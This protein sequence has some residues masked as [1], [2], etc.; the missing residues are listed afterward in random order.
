MTS[1]RED[2]SKPLSNKNVSKS[3]NDRLPEDRGYGGQ[4]S[5]GK[6]GKRLAGGG[7]RA[8]S[9]RQDTSVVILLLKGFY[10]N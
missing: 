6:T 8:G 7:S 5:Q 4:D 3:A 9:N 1:T 10:I 2:S